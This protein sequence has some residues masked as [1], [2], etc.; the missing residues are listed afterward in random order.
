MGLKTLF[1]FSFGWFQV[2]SKNHI[3]TEQMCIQSWEQAVIRQRI[4]ILQC[5][6]SRNHDPNRFVYQKFNCKF[7]TEKSDAKLKC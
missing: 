6:H 2:S 4:H 5:T 1:H 7:M 3:K